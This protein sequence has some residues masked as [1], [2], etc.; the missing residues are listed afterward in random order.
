MYKHL[1]LYVVFPFTLAFPW[2]CIDQFLYWF[3]PPEIFISF[4][5]WPSPIKGIIQSDTSKHLWKIEL[6]SKP[7]C[8]KKLWS[9]SI[10]QI[11]KKIFKMHIMKKLCLD[12][13]S[14]LHQ[15]ELIFSF[16]F[17]WKFW[18]TL[19]LSIFCLTFHPS[20]YYYSQPI[21]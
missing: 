3:F 4:C 12:F 14:S 19:V 13:K 16:Q 18:C 9:L 10:L 6:K 5:V 7:I 15:N 17:T 11:F 21:E 2:T 8:V 20:Q 1:W